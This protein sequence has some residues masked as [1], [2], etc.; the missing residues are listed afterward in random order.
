MFRLMFDGN[1]DPDRVPHCL[2]K[3]TG[4]PDR[5]TQR[6]MHYNEGPFKFITVSAV[7][8]M[9]LGITNIILITNNGKEEDLV[10]ITLISIA[11][12]IIQ[13]GYAIYLLNEKNVLTYKNPVE[14]KKWNIPGPEDKDS[15]EEDS[16]PIYFSTDPK[17]KEDCPEPELATKNTLKAVTIGSDQ[18]TRRLGLQN[19]AKE[20]DSGYGDEMGAPNKHGSSEALIGDN[21]EN[22]WETYEGI[23]VK[24]HSKNPNGVTSVDETPCSISEY[25]LYTKDC[26]EAKIES[27]KHLCKSYQTH[28]YFC[29]HKSNLNQDNYLCR[30]LDLVS[31][32]ETR[33]KQYPPE[34]FL[35]SNDTPDSHD[36]GPDPEK[37]QL[38]TCLGVK[39]KGPSRED[40]YTQ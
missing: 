18:K 21:Y 37:I 1:S 25:I 40:E 33:D 7:L 30:D 2:Y 23:C 32:R 28:T 15:N 36:Q 3:S 8:I 13:G 19:E 39:P 26:G 6:W 4:D 10:F 24:R 9:A 38:F 11:T 5:T 20:D 27:T 14:L 16:S 12:S 31:I 22:T 17:F 34:T 35:Q 29:T